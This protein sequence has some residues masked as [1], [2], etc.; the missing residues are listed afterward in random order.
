MQLLADELSRDEGNKNHMYLD[1]K[2]IPTIGIGHNLRDKPISNVAVQQIFNDDISE[3]IADLNTHIPWYTQLSDARQR[4][5]ANMAYNM[6]I[7]GLLQWHGMFSALQSGDFESAA[8]HIEGSLLAKEL[9]VRS[10]R[11]ASQMR[12]G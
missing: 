9:P 8:Q 4:V 12:A 3:V 5:L 11:L 7:Q 1:Q 6:G 2:G 10:A